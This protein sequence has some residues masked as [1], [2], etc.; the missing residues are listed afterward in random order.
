MYYFWWDAKKWQRTDYISIAWQKFSNRYAKYHISWSRIIVCCDWRR[1]Q[2]SDLYC[3]CRCGGRSWGPWAH[4]RR[5][6][7][8]LLR[9]YSVSHRSASIFSFSGWLGNSA[10]ISC[11]SANQITWRWCCRICR[12]FWT[13]FAIWAPSFMFMFLLMVTKSTEKKTFNSKGDIGKMYQLYYIH[14]LQLIP[15]I[16]IWNRG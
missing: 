10:T 8:F 5:V 12:S 9:R 16:D 2:L 7:I 11:N 6:C 13:H 1:S 4:K 3:W 15:K 14:P